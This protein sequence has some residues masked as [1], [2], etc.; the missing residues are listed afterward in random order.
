MSVALPSMDTITGALLVGT[1]AATL[2]YGMELVQLT[3]YFRHF[4]KDPPMLKLFV[5]FTCA[6]DTASIIGSYAGVYLYTITHAN[7]PTYFLTQNWTIPMFAYITGALAASVQAFLVVRYYRL[8]KNIII[9]LTLGVLVLAALGGAW[10]SGIMIT[11]HPAFADRGKLRIPAAIF[12]ATAALTDLCI[13]AV[14]IWEFRKVKTGF[15]NTNSIIKKLVAL[16]LQSGAAGATISIAGLIAFLFN[17]ESNVPVGIIYSLGRIY[18][19]TMLANL[20]IRRSG[21]GGSQATSTSVNALSGDRVPPSRSEF[22]EDLGGIHVHR[23]AVVHIDNRQDYSDSSVERARVKDTPVV[24]IE[25]MD[26]LRKT[27]LWVDS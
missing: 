25:M 17:N 10:T 7:D 14:L 18:I 21:R 4:P 19:L 26:N 27:D 5:V 11:L 13:A 6:I 16:T 3:Y 2:L 9:T 1:W 12:L 15:V 23:T 24:E 22:A 8:T 20:N